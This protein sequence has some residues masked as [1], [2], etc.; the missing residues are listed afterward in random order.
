MNSSPFH[1]RPH[2][3]ESQNSPAH[4]PE[5]WFSGSPLQP[6]QQSGEQLVSGLNAQQREAVEHSGSPLLIVA[7]AGSGKTAVLTRRIAYL[8]QQRGV[9]PHQILAI[10]FTNK[11]AREMRERVG[12]LVGPVAD[13]MSVSYTHLRAHET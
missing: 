9:G 2:D 6:I 3:R 11:A 4:N 10:T 13:R 7:G 1:P 12:N 8:M 5:P